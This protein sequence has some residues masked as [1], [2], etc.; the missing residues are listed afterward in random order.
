MWLL[1]NVYDD[2]DLEKENKNV[3]VLQL[4]LFYLFKD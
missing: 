2:G 4:F 3:I 1:S